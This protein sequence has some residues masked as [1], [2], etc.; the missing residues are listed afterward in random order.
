[1]AR[2]PKCAEIETSEWHSRCSFDFHRKLELCEDAAMKI[3]EMVPAECLELLQQTAIGRL[4]CSQSGQAYV[5]PVYFVA[6]KNYIYGFTT[7]GQKIEWMRANPLV[8]LE[9]DEITSP[10]NWRSVIVFGRYQEL[11][12][13]PRWASARHH[14][15]CLLEKRAVWWEPAFVSSTHRGKPHSSEPIF[16][17]ISIDQITGHRAQSDP[18]EMATPQPLE[19]QRPEG[20]VSKWLHGIGRNPRATKD[21]GSV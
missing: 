10:E 6:N 17:R 21:P 13:D 15:H 8:C 20:W 2:W 9:A 18:H 5:V 19:S 12:D 4:G 14:A 1:M 11:Q 16:Y 7:L 3:E